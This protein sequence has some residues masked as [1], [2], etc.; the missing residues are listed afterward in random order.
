[1]MYG[2]KHARI[3]DEAF[4]ALTSELRVRVLNASATGCL[5]ES[6]RALPVGTVAGL[7]VRLL[8]RD[9]DDEVQITRCQALAGA[10]N[11]FHIAMQFLSTAPPYAG[12]LRY[13]IHRELHT[14]AGWVH[15]PAG[16]EGQ[17]T[18]SSR[19]GTADATEK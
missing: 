6:T 19:R 10:G 16:T 5:I 18:D 1:M 15:A 17:S 14:F 11:I 7:R 9:Y 8:D 13:A 2:Q 12:S 3:D 4:G